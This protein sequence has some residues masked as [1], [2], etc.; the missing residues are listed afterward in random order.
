M[1]CPRVN[2]KSADSERSRG[3]RE[4]IKGERTRERE[5]TITHTHLEL[6]ATTHAVVEVDA[7][8]RTIEADV[9][10]ERCAL[11]LRLKVA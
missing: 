8:A 10:G 6:V 7:G 4:R 2:A 11:R 5:H 1:P 9:V 3:S